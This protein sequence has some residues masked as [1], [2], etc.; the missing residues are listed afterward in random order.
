MPVAEGTALL[1]HYQQP[2]NVD[3]KFIERLTAYV[4]EQR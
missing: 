1:N 3:I 2:A 4:L